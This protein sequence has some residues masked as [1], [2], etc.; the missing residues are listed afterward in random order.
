MHYSYKLHLTKTCFESYLKI[1]CVFKELYADSVHLYTT[2]QRKYKE[3]KMNM[4]KHTTRQLVSQETM[5]T[6]FLYLP[7]DNEN[8]YL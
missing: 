3:H 5:I 6:V 7:L 2:E 4:Q 1:L 8:L